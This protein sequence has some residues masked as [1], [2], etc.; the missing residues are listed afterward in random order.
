MTAC[1]TARMD[2]N[3]K[4]L[5][6]V[7]ARGT[8]FAVWI[9]GTGSRSARRAGW[10]AIRADVDAFVIVL[11]KQEYLNHRYL[12]T[13]PRRAAYLWF[14]VITGISSRRFAGFWHGIFDGRILGIFAGS[15][16]ALIIEERIEVEELREG[17]FVVELDTMQ[18]IVVKVEA[19][20]MKSEQIREARKLEALMGVALLPALFAPILVVAIQGFWRDERFESLFD[21]SVRR[22]R[23]KR[24]NGQWYI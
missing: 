11:W 2:H 13:W 23:A 24:T 22:L 16:A 17:D 15:V 20:Q 19:F 4:K 18:S 8:R 7:L 1:G 10:A 3:W 9:A 14:R 12:G 5:V 21:R 6:V